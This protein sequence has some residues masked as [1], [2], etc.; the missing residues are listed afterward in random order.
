MKKY[1][2]YF[3]GIWRA[4]WK[5]SHRCYAGDSSWCSLLAEWGQR[6]NSVWWGVVVVQVMSCTGGMLG[7]LTS[8]PFGDL[9]NKEVEW[10][11]WYSSFWIIKDMGRKECHSGGSFPWV[12]SM[13]AA[14]WHGP[15]VTLLLGVNIPHAPLDSSFKLLWSHVWECQKG[16]L[17]WRGSHLPLRYLP[18]N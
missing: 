5:F 1:V 3:W 16:V 11:D 13:A 15:V 18:S 9:V 8:G 10:D 12:V 7:E 6:Y 2:S 14:V 4:L 17:S